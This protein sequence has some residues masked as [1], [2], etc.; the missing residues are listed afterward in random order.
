MK[1]DRSRLQ[2]TFALLSL[3]LCICG[4][5]HPDTA[6]RAGWFAVAVVCFLLE[7]KKAN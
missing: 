2:F 7:I 5:Y 1:R 3:G 6:V 4:R